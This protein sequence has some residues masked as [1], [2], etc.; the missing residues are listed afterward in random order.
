[1]DKYFDL[2][3]FGQYLKYDLNNLRANYGL[4]LL[5]L[6]CF[7][8]VLYVIYILINLIFNGL[9][10]GWADWH[11]SSPS[12]GFRIG[13]FFVCLIVLV[14]SFPSQQY[15]KLT[16]KRYGS[17]WLLIPASRNSSR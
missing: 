15:G 17:D 2:K 13:M 7:P 4:T 10:G 5:I 3:R 16:E 14:V 9:L 8:V 1:M 11:W 6:A 12:M